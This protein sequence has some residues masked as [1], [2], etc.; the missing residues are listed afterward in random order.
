MSSAPRVL[1]VALA[2]VAISLPAAAQ[3]EATERFSK[4][5]HLDQNGAFV[6]GVD[7][8]R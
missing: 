6:S 8:V 5:A 7:T 3:H 2:A 1:V 4:T